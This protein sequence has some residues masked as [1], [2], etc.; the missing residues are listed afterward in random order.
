MQSDSKRC[1]KQ[2]TGNATFHRTSALRLD[3]A[4][5]KSRFLSTEYTV[6]D[7][8]HEA[9]AVA[10]G[11]EHG[12]ADVCKAPTPPFRL[13]VANVHLQVSMQLSHA[14]ALLQLVPFVRPF[15]KRT[16]SPH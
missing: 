5:H 10:S 7:G 3:W 1:E 8:G 9:C 11:E 16:H 13:H 12:G 6:I 15:E 14:L 4:E 2:S